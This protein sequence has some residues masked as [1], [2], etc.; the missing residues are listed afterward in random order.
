MQLRV[1]RNLALLNHM[2]FVE[3]MQVSDITD[4]KVHS[5]A[6]QCKHKISLGISSTKEDLPYA[7]TM[8]QISAL[9]SALPSFPPP[10]QLS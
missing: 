9:D 2:R 7:G 5:F 6:F 4:R 3:E 1:S 8:L 10:S